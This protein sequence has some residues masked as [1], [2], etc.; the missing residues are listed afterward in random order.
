MFGEHDEDEVLGEEKDDVLGE[1]KDEVLAHR[2]VHTE[3]WRSHSTYKGSFT[4]N[5]RRTFR[6][7]RFFYPPSTLDGNVR[8]KCPLRN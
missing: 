1:D 7:S 6:F 2:T 3:K 4:I 8:K 5:F